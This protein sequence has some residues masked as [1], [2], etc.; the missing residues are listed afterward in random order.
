MALIT[1]LLCASF[2][3]LR[4]HGWPEAVEKSNSPDLLSSSNQ[5]A[6]G[7][8]SAPQV[9]FPRECEHPLICDTS[10]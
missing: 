9:F 4:S 5:I 7:V 3:V 6:N 2:L 1:L 8:S 10:F